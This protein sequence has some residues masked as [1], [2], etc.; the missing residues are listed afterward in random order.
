MVSGFYITA[1][2]LIIQNRE[3]AFSSRR[4]ELDYEVNVRTYRKL[5]AIEARIEE[6]Q[7]R[8]NTLKKALESLKNNEPCSLIC[9]V[10]G[11]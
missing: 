7:S 3:N 1:F 6:V 11:L 8:L 5:L 2:L 4:A 10:G 9:R